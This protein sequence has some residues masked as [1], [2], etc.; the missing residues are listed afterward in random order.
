V[1]DLRSTGTELKGRYRIRV[2]LRP[3]KNDSGTIELHLVDPIDR[4]QQA[5]GQIAGSAHSEV[6]GKTRSVACKV[7]PGGRLNIRISG[8]EHTLTFKTKYRPLPS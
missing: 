6:N 7:R 1:L 8:E 4:L 2:P 5:G 3:S